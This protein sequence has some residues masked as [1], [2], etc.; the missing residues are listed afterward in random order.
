MRDA[1][2]CAVCQSSKR[3]FTIFTL[4]A[5]RDYAVNASVWYDILRGRAAP[6]R[7]QRVSTTSIFHTQARTHSAVT[8]HTY[9]IIQIVIGPLTTL[10]RLIVTSNAQKNNAQSAVQLNL[11][12]LT[13]SWY[14]QN[15]KI[16]FNLD[17]FG[18]C[19]VGRVPFNNNQTRGTVTFHVAIT[20]NRNRGLLSFTFFILYW[21]YDSRTL[22][23]CE[24]NTFIDQ[25]F[26]LK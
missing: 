9:A 11:T 24:N 6:R 15:E 18:G 21:L 25:S 14:V 20:N 16:R 1:R 22:L 13:V 26:S 2:V 8:A 12:E 23:N 5:R 4:P 10:S 19:Q 17:L 7:A 3:F